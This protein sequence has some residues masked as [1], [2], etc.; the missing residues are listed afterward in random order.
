MKS[1]NENNVI[2]AEPYRVDKIKLLDVGSCYNPLADFPELDV[3]AIDIAPATDTVMHC[4]FLAVPLKESPPYCSNNRVEALPPMHFDAVVFSLLLEYFPTSEQRLHCCQKA[5]D[6]LK[7][8]GILLIV[9]PDSRHQ[10][11]NAKLM[12][13]WRYSLGLLGFTRIR[14]DKLQH[15]TC[16]AFRKSFVK[17][18][19][20]QWCAANKEDYMEPALFIPQDF[21][22]IPNVDENVEF[23]QERTAQDDSD[24][25]EM[26]A[27]MPF[28]G[29]DDDEM[30]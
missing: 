30:S 21:N 2:S 23:Q 1:M 24:I 13:N 19:S 28:V 25:S 3:T 4:D 16:M 26:F 10:G 22:T 7:P 27:A 11:A 17:E 12:K 5:Y 14:L 15:V 6:V 20:Q 29:D 8:E 18:I 9:T